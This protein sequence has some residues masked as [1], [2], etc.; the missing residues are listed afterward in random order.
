[1]ANGAPPILKFH[2]PQTRLLACC[3]LS[4]SLALTASPVRADLFGVSVE[5]Q[6]KMGQ[7][8]AADI[9]KNSPIVSGPVEAW[10]QRVGAKLAAVS[11]PEFQYS[12]HVV[13]SPEINAFCLPGGH[14]YVYTGLRKVVNTDD[15]L[16]GILAH[17]ITHAEKQHYAK[18]YKKNS[19]RGAILGVGSLLLGVPALGQSLL[20]MADFALTQK[21][22]RQD[23]SEADLVGVARMQRAGYDPH[24]MINV[25]QRLSEEE[26]GNDLDRWLSDHPEGKKRVQAVKKLLGEAQ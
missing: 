2:R 12:F 5:K 26:D 7:Q 15:E 24:G 10:V 11:D 16:A 17:E 25:L 3:G 8:A 4:L 6:K 22:S 14:V 9:E 1:M 13:D 18:Q 20:S 19:T 23:E 21:Y